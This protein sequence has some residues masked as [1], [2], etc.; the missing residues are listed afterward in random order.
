MVSVLVLTDPVYGFAV[1]RS[2][3]ARLTLPILA[4]PEIWA[5]HCRVA[6]A[7]HGRDYLFSA[8]SASG[9]VGC[10]CG[11]LIRFIAPDAW[12]HGPNPEHRIT[13]DPANAA[14]ELLNGAPPSEL[15]FWVQQIHKRAAE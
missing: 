6:P 8:G 5:A 15:L 11:V 1:L 13:L 2:A 12:Q 4:N 10:G 7:G 14:P 3:S 9:T